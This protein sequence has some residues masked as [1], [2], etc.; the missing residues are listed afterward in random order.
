[1]IKVHGA[2]NIPCTICGQIF[3]RNINLRE[4]IEQTHP[5]VSALQCPERNCLTFEKSASE[6][7]NHVRIF[8]DCGK[9]SDLLKCFYCKV[10]TKS[11]ECMMDHFLNT[12]LPKTL[13]CPLCT[14]KFVMSFELK[15]HHK[16]RHEPPLTSVVCLYCKR[17]VAQNGMEAHT[18]SPCCGKCEKK[19]PC[20]GLLCRHWVT[21]RKVMNTNVLI[22]ECQK[23]YPEQQFQSVNHQ[24]NSQQLN[25]SKTCETLALMIPPEQENEN[26]A[27]HRRSLRSKFDFGKS[28]CD[29]ATKNRTA[30]YI[31]VNITSNLLEPEILP[32]Q[33]SIFPRTAIL[34]S[35]VKTSRNEE[36][37]TPKNKD[38]DRT[39]RSYSSVKNAAGANCF[40]LHKTQDVKCDLCKKI[41]HSKYRMITHLLGGHGIGEGKFKCRPCNRSYYEKSA[42]QKHQ[43]ASIPTHFNYL[44]ENV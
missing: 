2:I 16:E 35:S 3:T 38:I 26:R 43:R 37:L 32:T 4:H 7:A 9:K 15:K 25:F 44:H 28:N 17:V 36:N 29:S 6:L 18:K 30:G 40:D 12:H 14:K 21:C 11:K 41:L 31:K 10:T 19:L 34:Q 20:Y 42:L 22:I 24:G 33:H 27:E 5:T 1:M 8:H 13:K 23:K 39:K